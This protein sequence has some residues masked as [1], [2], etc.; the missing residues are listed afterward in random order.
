[1]M[2]IVQVCV[3]PSRSEILRNLALLLGVIPAQAGIQ[4]NST[5]V[6]ERFSGCPIGSGMTWE[7]KSVIPAQP[8]I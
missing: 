2:F 7:E 6:E 3:I 8:G 1:M 4:F 5:R